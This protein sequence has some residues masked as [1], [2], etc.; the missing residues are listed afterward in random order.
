[1]RKKIIIGNWKMNNTVAESITFAKKLNDNISEKSNCDI[2]ICPT[3][4]ALKDV[5]DVLSQSCIKVGAQNVHFENSGAY[6]GEVSVV[7]LKEINIDYC[8]I[9]HSERRKYFNETDADINKKAK[10]LIENE[11]IPVIC[12]GEKKEQRN[13]NIHLELIKSQIVSAL[14]GISDISNVIIAYEPIW[15]IG[16]GVTATNEQANEMCQYIREVIKDMYGESSSEKVRILYG[17]SVNAKNSKELLSG[18]N[19]DGALVGGASLKLDFID[20]INSVNSK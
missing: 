18:P 19:I 12:V 20:I 14:E 17:G 5:K 16:T 7:M 1:M 2:A 11:I 9:G 4:I 3:Y 8:I 6:T 10:K 15:A 13:E